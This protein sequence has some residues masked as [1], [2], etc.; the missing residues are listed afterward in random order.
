MPVKLFNLA[1]FFLVVT[2]G[3]AAGAPSARA[4]LT[5]MPVRVMFTDRDRT[6]EITLINSSENTNTYR[7]EL[8]SRK[9]KEIGGYEQLTEP[10]DPLFKP[11]ETLVFSPRQV[12]IPPG[13]Q[14]R[15]RISLRRPP[16][17]PDG[18]YRA[19]LVLRKIGSSEKRKQQT[20]GGM[21]MQMMINLGFSIPI[22]VRQGAYDAAL[23]IGTPQFLP[24]AKEG[25]P[26]RLRVEL[27]RS[28][29]NS[30]SGSIRAYWTPAGGKETQISEL[31]N[32]NVFHEIS[33]RFV[34]MN[35]QRSD[36]KGGTLR[37]VVE[38]LEEN[39]NQIL[40]EKVFPVG[41]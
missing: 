2:I 13:G 30:I 38:G 33:K 15:V 16:G 10:L 41:G 3:L 14:Q 6:Q 8:G 27:N 29:K 12:T 21:N 39:K 4:D 11:D 1:L 34:D 17:L 32:I 7:L 40:D 28:G 26:A 36:I 9:M 5:I 22:I 20:G 18:E 25:A 35:L 23:K 24:P 31:N 19:H 37:I